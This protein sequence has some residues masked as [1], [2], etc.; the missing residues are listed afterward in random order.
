VLLLHGPHAGNVYPLL[1]LVAEL[2]RRGH[3]VTQA[4]TAE[5]APLADRAGAAPLQYESAVMNLDPAEVFAADD[6][7]ATPHM[8]YLEENLQV[9]R[10]VE[11]ACD[12]SPPDVVVYEDFPFIAGQLLA[13]RWN[14][15]A[16]RIS[17]GFATNHAYSYYADMVADSGIPGPLTLQRFR[18]A[19][20]DLLAARGVGASP[21][22]FWYRVEDLNLVFIPR[23]FQFAGGTFDER[24]VFVGPAL[25]ESG[26]DGW[27]PPGDRPVVLVS[28]GTSFNDH[29][30]LFRDCAR[31]FAGSRWH[32]VM[33]VGSRV[34]PAELGPLP[35]N[36]EA[37]GWLS[38][39][40][41]LEHAQL[42]V[43]HGGMGTVMQALHFGRPMVVI[44][45]H[46]FECVPMARRVD[47]LGLGRHLEA[48][49]L[50]GAALRAAVDELAGDAGTLARVREMQRCVRTAGGAVRAA[51]EVL[52]RAGGASPRANGDHRRRTPAKRPRPVSQ[53]SS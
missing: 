11:A 48:Q 14:R 34:D 25:T 9:L 28:L 38:H 15:P 7:G 32:V 13:A 53:G 12:G 36:V 27:A 19:L 26:G 10:A 42:C 41:V 23:A 1:P 4:T 35:P 21:E 49:P 33:T 5:F 50:D 40:A 45:H 52:A 43:T 30:E 44:P 46:A 29:P 47:E 24:F 2:T 51:D 6:D 17:V 20:A 16:V 18:T 22:G 3:R 31:A 39:A 37:H 8:L